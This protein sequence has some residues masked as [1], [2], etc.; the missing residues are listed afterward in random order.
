VKDRGLTGVEK[1]QSMKLKKAAEKLAESVARDVRIEFHLPQCEGH[2]SS[3]I[4]VKA[5]FAS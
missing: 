1:L 3:F 4:F 2:H 5:F